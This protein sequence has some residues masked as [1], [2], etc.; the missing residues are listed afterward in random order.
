MPK[1]KVIA[2]AGK[3]GTGKTTFTALL[4]RHLTKKYKDKAILAVDADANANLNE[5]L[6]LEVKETISMALDDIKD[7]RLVPS[8]MTKD[9]FMEMRISQAMVETDQIDLLVMG[10][11]EGP[12]CYCYPNDLLRK[13]LE[14]L[15]EN[16][17][18]VAV[19]NEAGMEHLSRRIINNVDYILIT[20]DATARG[21][22]SAGRAYNIIKTLKISSGKVYLIITKTQN[23][24]VSTLRG[25]I[26]KTGLELL[27]TVPADDMVVEFDLNDRALFELPDDSPAVQ[28]VEEIAEKLQL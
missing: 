6:G 2:V 24:E 19:D 12:G 3:G 22:R 8:G 23:Q 1:E 11:P 5:A 21:V 15:R 18:F 13:Y 20:S 16:Y 10:N 4:L 28:A 27:G 25:E 7:P 14:Q 26:E 17:D 9:I